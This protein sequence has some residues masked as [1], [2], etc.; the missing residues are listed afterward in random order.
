MAKNKFTFGVELFRILKTETK[1][2]FFIWLALIIFGITKVYI[3][4]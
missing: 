2:V 1:I 3:F 4:N